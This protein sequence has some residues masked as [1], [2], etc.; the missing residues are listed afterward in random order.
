M[1]WQLNTKSF[2]QKLHILEVLRNRFV[3]VGM[4]E[5]LGFGGQASDF[6]PVNITPSVKPLCRIYPILAVL[7]PVNAVPHII[8]HN[9][10]HIYLQSLA[11]CEDKGIWRRAFFELEAPAPQ[12][13]HLL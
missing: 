4:A 9:R 2:A 7:H 1:S 12:E 13:L 10:M 8:E 3:S 5:H 6:N 11:V